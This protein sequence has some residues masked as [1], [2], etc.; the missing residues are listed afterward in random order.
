LYR[1][2]LFVVNKDD[3]N[4]KLNDVKI[5]LYEEIVVEIIVFKNI[6]LLKTIKTNKTV[7]YFNIYMLD[8]YRNIKKFGEAKDIFILDNSIYILIEDNLYKYKLYYYNS[9][10]VYLQYYR[11]S[12]GSKNIIYRKFYKSFFERDVLNK[13]N[14]VMLNFNLKE[15]ILQHI[16][17]IEKNNQDEIIITDIYGNK[18]KLIY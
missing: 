1:N 9:E 8:K 11:D 12:F 15:L 16:N 6:F 17:S 5:E 4:I 18:S 3:K 13:N 2:N 14:I 7:E 10:F